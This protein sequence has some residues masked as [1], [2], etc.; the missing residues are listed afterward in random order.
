MKRIIN[1]SKPSPKCPEI[2]SKGL[3]NWMTT[4]SMQKYTVL[5]LPSGSSQKS[6]CEGPTSKTLPLCSQ[7]HGLNWRDRQQ[8]QRESAT[9]VIDGLE[10]L[11]CAPELKSCGTQLSSTLKME[12]SVTKPTTSGRVSS[13]KR[14]IRHKGK[15]QRVVI[16]VCCP[17]QAFL[18]DTAS[19]AVGE[20]TE[21]TNAKTP[22]STA[23][24]TEGALSPTTTQT[25]RHATGAWRPQNGREIAAPTNQDHLPCNQWNPFAELLE[26]WLMQRRTAL[27]LPPMLTSSCLG[28]TI[29]NLELNIEV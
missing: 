24:G 20:D 5:K 12:G 26:A 25:G 2:S 27:P 9:K 11:R 1:T 19:G 21:Q 13:L 15:A 22:T 3:D 16:P 7:E 8:M 4:A 17:I 28:V 6:G 29:D 23:P 14:S 18:E 10:Q